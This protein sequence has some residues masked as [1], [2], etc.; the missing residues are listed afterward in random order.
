MASSARG[1][2]LRRDNVDLEYLVAVLV[3]GPRRAP[4][5]VSIE[6]VGSACRIRGASEEQSAVS[7]LRQIPAGSAQQF[8]AD[9]TVF[10]I[11]KQRND[12]YLSGL[13]RAEAKTNDFPVDGANV[14]GQRA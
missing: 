13:A 9:T 7:K 2:Q 1:P 6:A 8:S 4:A 14:T 10:E 5:Q 3:E 12:L 11:R